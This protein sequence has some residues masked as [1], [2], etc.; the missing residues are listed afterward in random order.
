M[1]DSCQMFLPFCSQSKLLFSKMNIGILR[2]IHYTYFR[3]EVRKFYW[4]DS[5]NQ[6]M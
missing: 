3:V 2:L 6:E 4:K 1:V 5:W